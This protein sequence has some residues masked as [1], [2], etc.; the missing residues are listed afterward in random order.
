MVS[1]EDVDFAHY[2]DAEE[3]RKG[4]LEMCE[5]W[6]KEHAR[7]KPLPGQIDLAEELGKTNE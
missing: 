5:K 7:P 4:H 6:A 2:D 1:G 3:A